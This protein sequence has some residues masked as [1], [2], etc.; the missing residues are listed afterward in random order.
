MTSTTVE[1]LQT[2]I[3]NAC[4]NDGTPSSGHEVRNADA[5]SSFLGGSGLDVETYEAAPGRV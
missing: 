4:V 2:M 1:L 5:L 3:R